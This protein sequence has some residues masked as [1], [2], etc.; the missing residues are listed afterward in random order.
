MPILT[1][2][3]PKVQ[4][5]DR[6]PRMTDDGRVSQLP[7]EFESPDAATAADSPEADSPEAALSGEVVVRVA[8]SGALATPTWSSRVAALR[9]RLPELAR[10]PAVVATATVGTGIAVR[11]VREAVRGGAARSDPTPVSVNVHLVNHVHVVHH[12]VHHVVREIS[13]PALPDRSL[14]EP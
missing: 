9:E 7:E 11:L 13:R 2:S 5:L 1:R 10:H 4:H 14:G 6:A 12:V 8:P 3:G